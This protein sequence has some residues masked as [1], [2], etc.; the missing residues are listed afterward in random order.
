MDLEMFNSLPDFM[1]EELLAQMREENQAVTNR[2]G[3]GGGG[4]RATGGLT[5]T[6]TLTP[7]PQ[8]LT[9]NP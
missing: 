1:Q 6:L 7:N 4:G 5:L 3:G 8:P 9:P 2:V